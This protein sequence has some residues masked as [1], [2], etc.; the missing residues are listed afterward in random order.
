MATDVNITTNSSKK[1]IPMEHTEIHRSVKVENAEWSIVFYSN[2]ENS[3][4]NHHDIE[5]DIDGHLFHEFSD[6]LVKTN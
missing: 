4:N 6:H 2:F 1:E 5:N 3:A